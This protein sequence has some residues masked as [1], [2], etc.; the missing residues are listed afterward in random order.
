M[1]K[2]FIAVFLSFTLS[3]GAVFAISANS[4]QIV[5]NFKARHEKIL[6][7]TLPLT[8]SG[9]NDILEYEY[10]LNGLEALQKRLLEVQKQ[11]E[12]KKEVTTRQRISLENA[13]LTLNESIRQ[14]EGHIEQTKLRIYE[15]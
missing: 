15:K 10:R 3:I 14:T 4:A 5:D 6:F 11:Y 13:I 9:A 2:I 1:R 7:E 8:A 12:E